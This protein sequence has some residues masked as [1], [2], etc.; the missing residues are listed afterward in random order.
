MRIII[1]R[2]IQQRKRQQKA[3]YVIM[4][5]RDSLE[6]L[7]RDLGFPDGMPMF[8]VVSTWASHHDLSAPS[9]EL[10]SAAS[11]WVSEYVGKTKLLVDFASS[12]N[13][14][15]SIEFRP[16]PIQNSCCPSTN[17]VVSC[18]EE[19]CCSGSRRWRFWNCWECRAIAS[20]QPLLDNNDWFLVR[21]L[22]WRIRIYISISKL[23]FYD[24]KVVGKETLQLTRSLTTFK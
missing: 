5:P 1:F 3:V 13:N 4:L 12:I 17:W 14:S 18:D 6:D 8:D 11:G 15:S 16:V 10:Q 9:A 24:W 20:G 7:E 23:N 22:R 2:K 19:H 21:A